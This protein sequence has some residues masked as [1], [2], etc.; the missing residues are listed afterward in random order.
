MR[1]KKTSADVRLATLL[2]GSV[3]AQDLVFVLDQ[4]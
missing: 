2:H 3:I 1:H 4:V